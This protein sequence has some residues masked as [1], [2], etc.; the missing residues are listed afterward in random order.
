MIYE[1]GSLVSI[2]VAA[3]VAARPMP[4]VPDDDKRYFNGRKECGF[5]TNSG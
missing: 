5:H 4:R 1:H 3:N 2:E